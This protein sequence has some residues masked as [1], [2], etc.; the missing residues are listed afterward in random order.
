MAELRTGGL[1]IIIRSSVTEEVGKVVTCLQV[2]TPGSNYAPPQTNGEAFCWPES[3]PTAW[4]VSGYIKTRCQWTRKKGYFWVEGWGIYTP[5][6]L[7]PIDGDD[8][9]HEK[10]WQKELTNG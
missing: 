8:F 1:A 10:E 7:M 5:D 6:Q 3:Y 2:V 4:M 9:Q